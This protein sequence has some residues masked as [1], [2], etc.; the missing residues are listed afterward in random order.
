MRVNNPREFRLM[1]DGSYPNI[2]VGIFWSID[3]V[4]VGDGLYLQ[5]A[6]EY[7]DALQYGEHYDFWEK[8]KP[9]NDTQMKL[10]S[11]A[12]DFYPRGRMVCF[13]KR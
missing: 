11:H 6:E 5:E 10:K 1:A 13:P 12:Y 7:G 9:V 8:L 4:I 2:K 3:D